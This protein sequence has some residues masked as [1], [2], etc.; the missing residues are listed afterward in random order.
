MYAKNRLSI[1]LFEK[2]MTYRELSRLCGL[3]ISTLN[4]IANHKTDPKQSTMISIA[5]ALH[6]DVT[7]IF[8]L[9]WRRDSNNVEDYNH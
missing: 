8:C 4:N 9:D 3:S 7:D 5:H 2:N 6:M 1:I